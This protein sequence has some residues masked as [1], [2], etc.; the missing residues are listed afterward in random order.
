MAGAMLPTRRSERRI[1]ELKERNVTLRGTGENGGWFAHHFSVRI[2]IFRMEEF[3][4]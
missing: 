2:R 3:S 4:E 1:A